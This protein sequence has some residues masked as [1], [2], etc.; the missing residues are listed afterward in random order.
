[1]LN[2]GYFENPNTTH[3]P[4]FVCRS[5]V[6]RAPAAK[7]T[8]CQRHGGYQPTGT[9]VRHPTLLS[10]LAY[11][12]HKR[13]SE[14]PFMPYNPVLLMDSLTTLV[15]EQGEI[16]AYVNRRFA[17]QLAPVAQVLQGPHVVVVKVDVPYPEDDD[18][19]M[20]GF[21]TVEGWSDNHALLEMIAEVRT[22]ATRL[23]KNTRFTRH[24][25]LKR[26]TRV[27]MFSN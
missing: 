4:W 6:R 8:R 20:D 27:R 16:L 24:T 3:S 14:F 12:L 15:L 19:V 17:A 10:Y 26:L 2:H 7:P 1:M 5:V 13:R 23:L 22:E 18:Y 21:V 25:D 11:Y 9:S